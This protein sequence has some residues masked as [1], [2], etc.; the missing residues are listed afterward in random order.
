M[1]TTQETTLERLHAG[2][3]AYVECNRHALEHVTVDH[4]TNTLIVDTNGCKYRR[5]DGQR[6]GD[7]SWS[8]HYLR[9]GDE[10]AARYQR[11]RNIS[12]LRNVEWT[13]LSGETL[14]QVVKVL[15]GE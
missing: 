4:I 5:S 1:D 6:R 13:E 10:Y 14:A 8:Y 12:V 2:D 15:R 11:D 7:D 3:T 9:V